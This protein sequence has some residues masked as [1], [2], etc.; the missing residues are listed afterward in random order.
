MEHSMLA[1][2]ITRQG[3]GVA[4][5]SNRPCYRSLLEKTND[6]LTL[7]NNLKL[8]SSIYGKLNPQKQLIELVND[9]EM[10]FLRTTT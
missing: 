6:D 4:G 7:K 8:F 5:N 2:R 1:N 3:L 9:I 10:K